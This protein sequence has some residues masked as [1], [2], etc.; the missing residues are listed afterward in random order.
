MEA[1]LLRGLIEDVAILKSEMRAMKAKVAKQ[2]AGQVA[3]APTQARR[4]R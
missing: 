1:D 2:G 3:Q 4:R